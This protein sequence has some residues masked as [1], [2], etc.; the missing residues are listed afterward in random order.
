MIDTV[1]ESTVLRAAMTGK[2]RVHYAPVE[3]HQQYAS[4]VEASFACWLF[5]QHA[6]IKRRSST[7]QIQGLTLSR[8]LLS[9]Y[10]QPPADVEVMYVVDEP[11]A[12]INPPA[13]EWGSLRPHVGS[14]PSCPGLMDLSIRTLGVQG[15]RHWQPPGINYA[16]EPLGLCY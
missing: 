9:L 15:H 8:S 13:G 7:N 10:P 5:L 12:G 6:L 4:Q 11:L 3:I 14:S 2:S 1:I 16:S